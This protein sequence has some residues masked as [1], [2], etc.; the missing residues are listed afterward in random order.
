MQLEGVG[1]PDRG[2]VGWGWGVVPSHAAPSNMVGETDRS[3]EGGGCWVKCFFLF[4]SFFYV[5][6]FGTT[7]LENQTHTH[8]QRESAPCGTNRNF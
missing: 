6:P 8:I 4:F 1:G 2:G 3:K 5:W 7:L